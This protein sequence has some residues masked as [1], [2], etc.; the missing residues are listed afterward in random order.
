[1]K[2]TNSTKNFYPNINLTQANITSK[3][4]YTEEKSNSFQH[5]HR[6]DR[7]SYDRNSKNPIFDF[8]LKGGEST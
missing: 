6:P 3:H 8:F 4:R 5:E 1:M 2:H 7:Y